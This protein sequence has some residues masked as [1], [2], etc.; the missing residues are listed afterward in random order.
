MS[1]SGGGRFVVGRENNGAGGKGLR[2]PPPYRDDG[3]PGLGLPL[4]SAGS[5]GRVDGGGLAYSVEDFDGVHGLVGDERPD[6]MGLYDG[7][8]SGGGG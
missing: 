4:M 1:S 7:T 2:E 5:K 8:L 6:G 3:V